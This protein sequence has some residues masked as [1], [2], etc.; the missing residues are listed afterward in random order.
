MKR[1]SPILR[2]F[3]ELELKMGNTVE[4]VDEPAGTDCP[5]AVVFSGPLHIKEAADE[6]GF[7]SGVG[8]F[9]SRD[10]HYPLEKGIYCQRSRHVISGPL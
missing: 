10:P 2:P 9:E 4:R 1:L 7:G 5:L 8:V 3:Y 6:I